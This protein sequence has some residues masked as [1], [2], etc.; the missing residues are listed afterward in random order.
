MK[1]HGR[2]RSQVTVAYSDRLTDS[3]SD[4]LPAGKVIGT[5]SPG[6]TIRRGADVEKQIAIDNG[7]LRFQTLIK[8][9]WGRQ[10]IAYGPYARVNGLAFSVFLLNGHNTSESENIGQRLITRFWRWIRGSETENPALRLLRWLGCKH[11]QQTL[12]V[13]LWWIRNHKRVKTPRIDENLAVGWFPDEVPSNPLVQGNGAIVHATGPENGELWIRVGN[14]LLSTFKGLQNLPVYYIIIL[15]EKGAAYYAASVPNAHGLAAYPN[16]RPL[17]IDPFNDD[18]TVYAALYQ[19]VL[20]QAGFRVDTRVYSAHVELVPELA[21]W[22][23]TAHVADDLIGEGLLAGSPAEVGGAW[24][25]YRGSYG[26]TANGVRSL[27]TDSLAVLKPSAPSGL[28]HAIIETPA[29]VTTCGFLWRVRD[30]NNFWSF[31][32]SGNRCQLQIQE[33]GI[34]N[35]VAV[36]DEWYLAP[37]TTNSVQ[38]LDDGETFGLYLNGKQVFNTWFA[39]TRLQEATGVGLS[40]VEANESLYIR[41]FE[42][43]PRSLLIPRGLDLGSPWIAQGTQVV[44]SDDFDGAARN[45][46]R[47]TTSIGNK[48]WHKEIGRGAIALSGSGTAKVQANAQSPNPGR[49]AY[50]IA[51]DNPNLADLQVDITP[52]GTDRG[53]G[54]KS[55]AGLIFW[56]DA[57]NYIIVNNWLDDFYGGASV[58]SFFYLDGFEE[59][60]DAVWTNVGSRIYWGVPYTLRVVFDGMH[61]MAFVNGEPVLYRALTDVYPDTPRLAINRVG[62]VANWEW[63]N[64]TGSL[65]DN[66]IAKV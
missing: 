35:V 63:G 10:G 58:S 20:G 9:G 47:K 14:E 40:T 56:Q 29:I 65:F 7:A 44:V 4:N 41:H 30:K 13:F 2:K 60:Y 62:I 46:E 5:S 43:H 33:N 53:Q 6:G 38:I 36:S 37:N 34:S 59:L 11:K 26:L 51:W 24:S 16:M 52:P 8:P 22:Y 27:Q 32:I 1:L 57:N 45:L 50:T 64:D 28:I 25:V 61:Y 21:S 19:S 39:D 18:A 54:H 49:T 15:R 48:V 42:A 31:L 66:F 23:G 3:Y 55:R 12:R 17:A